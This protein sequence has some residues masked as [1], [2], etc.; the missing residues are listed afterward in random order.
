MRDFI[1]I[2]CIDC[3]DFYGCQEEGGK[4]EFCKYCN[5]DK[6]EREACRKESVGNHLTGVCSSCLDKRRAKI[7]KLKELSKR[8]EVNT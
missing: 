3:N 4:V 5:L 8:K 1:L 2:S 7:Q 6:E